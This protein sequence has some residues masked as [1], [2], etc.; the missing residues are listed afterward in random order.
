MEKHL[1]ENKK[2]NIEHVLVSMKTFYI[3]ENNKWFELHI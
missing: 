3:L 2:R 1:F